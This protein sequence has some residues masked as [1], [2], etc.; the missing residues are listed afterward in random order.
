MLSMR[1]FIPVCIIIQPEFSLEFKDKKFYGLSLLNLKWTKKWK[2][3]A[4]GNQFPHK[5]IVKEDNKF[6]YAFRGEII[7][8]M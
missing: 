3:K 5:I 7:T 1:G 4:R 8:T 2:A 6:N